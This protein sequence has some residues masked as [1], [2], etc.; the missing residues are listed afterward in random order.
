MRADDKFLYALGASAQLAVVAIRK[1]AV[2]R[3]NAGQNLAVQQTAADPDPGQRT[4]FKRI[5]IDAAAAWG[6]VIAKISANP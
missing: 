2:D 5:C 6:C 1:N 4:C 3:I